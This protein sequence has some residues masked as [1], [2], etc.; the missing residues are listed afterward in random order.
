M[1]RNAK[2]RTD[3]NITQL[4]TDEVIHCEK[5]TKR[6]HAG[7]ILAVDR[8]DLGVHHGESSGCSGP[9]AQEKRLPWHA[10]DTRYPDQR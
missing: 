2:L 8:L 4:A 6:Y 5:L 7:D 10:H 3:D 1:D 9:T